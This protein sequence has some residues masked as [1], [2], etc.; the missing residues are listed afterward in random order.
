MAVDGKCFVSLL[1]ASSLKSATDHDI[2]QEELDQELPVVYDGQVPM[3]ELLSR[4]VQ[5]IFA[6]LSELAETYVFALRL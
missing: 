6:E 5:A 1:G 2:A 4:V 3:G